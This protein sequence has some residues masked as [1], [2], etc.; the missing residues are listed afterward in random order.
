MTAVR[1]SLSTSFCRVT[2]VV[3]VAEWRLPSEDGAE[4]LSESEERRGK[5]QGGEPERRQRFAPLTR[6][7]SALSVGQVGGCG[8]LC[9]LAWPPAGADEVER[10]ICCAPL[11]RRASIHHCWVCSSSATHCLASLHDRTGPSVGLLLCCVAL[12]LQWRC[13]RLRLPM[14]GWATST[15]KRTCPRPMQR[16]RLHLRPHRPW[17]R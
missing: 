4:G 16:H 7:T 12:A 2:E 11:V 14:F 8:H 15:D 10:L 9:H 13:R 1:W 3:M 17:E 6:L 5:S